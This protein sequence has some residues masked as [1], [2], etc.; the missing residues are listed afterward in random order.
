[1]W[2]MEMDRAPGNGLYQACG[3]SCK[4]NRLSDKDTI[5]ICAE[6]TYRIPQEHPDTRH[7]FFLRRFGI[8]DIIG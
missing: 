1:M 5:S 8:Q 7:K 6:G 3:N 2:H 4:T